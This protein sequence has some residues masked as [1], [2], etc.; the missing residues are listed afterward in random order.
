MQDC[1][2]AHTPTRG[3]PWSTSSLN[4]MVNAFIDQPA[5]P[6]RYRSTTGRIR[7]K[8]HSAGVTRCAATL[9][10]ST[11]DPDPSAMFSAPRCSLTLR[12]KRRLWRESTI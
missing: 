3:K 7:G 11:M 9:A 2:V 4:A 12:A 10:A 1:S 8:V 5:S 6:A